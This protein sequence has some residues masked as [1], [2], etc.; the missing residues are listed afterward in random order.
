MANLCIVGAR[1][2][3]GVAELHSDILKS[4]LFKDFFDMKPNK[5]QNKTNGVTP[6]RWL[7]CC[8]PDL[9][10]WLDKYT[11]CDDWILDMDKLKKFTK[12]ADDK[13]ARDE[14]FAIKRANK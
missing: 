11:G 6:R 5:F 7:K 13:K 9:A 2:V 12:I 1:F 4:T 14:F 10:K 3:N 8:N